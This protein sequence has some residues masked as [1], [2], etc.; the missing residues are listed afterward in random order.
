MAA[1]R[2]DAAATLARAE[3]ELSAAR[4]RF[5]ELLG[6]VAATRPVPRAP[7]TS[8]SLSTSPRLLELQ[9]QV[10]AAEAE[11]RARDAERAPGVFLDVTGGLDGDDD[12]ALGAGL[13]LDYAI[14]ISGRRAAAIDA[15]RAE[16]ERLEAELVL[17]E[18]DL[19]REISD[20]R[21]R[22]SALLAERRASA[23][24]E[25]AA[26]QALE[27]AEASFASGRVDILDLL[28]LGQD[29]D[30]AA[31]RRIDVDAEYRLAGYVRL[32]ASGVLLDVLGFEAGE[33]SQ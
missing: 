1:R 4:A 13:R 30:Q 33:V 14:D 22:E 20:A 5:S 8:V 7:D 21:S 17:A 28:D 16:V 19:R 10:R 12:P 24:A 18:S 26:R 23:A 27:D 11:L 32:A 31:S 9:A 29:L 15:A 25:T 2:A 6:N 3:G